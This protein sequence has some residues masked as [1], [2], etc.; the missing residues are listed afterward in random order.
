MNVRDDTDSDGGLWEK[1]NSAAPTSQHK[2]RGRPSP[3]PTKTR[4]RETTLT[5]SFESLK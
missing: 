1:Y 4:S 3:T 2:K 5:A